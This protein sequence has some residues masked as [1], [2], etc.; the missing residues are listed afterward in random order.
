MKVG[1]V[2]KPVD[3]IEQMVAETLSPA[4]EALI[5]EAAKY[6]PHEGEGWKFTDTGSRVSP[7]P[8]DT[9]LGGAVHELLKKDHEIFQLEKRIE[10]LLKICDESNRIKQKYLVMY[11]RE[12][13]QRKR[14]EHL[15]MVQKAK[16]EVVTELFEN[17]LD[18]F[19]NKIN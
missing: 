16:V 17:F 8:P 15:E 7:P 12:E 13:M 4:R 3:N 11:E 14:V 9:S 10:E 19:L 6:L 5:D 18:R 1:N 2:E